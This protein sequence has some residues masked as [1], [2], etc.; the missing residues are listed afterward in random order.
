MKRLSVL[1]SSLFIFLGLFVSCKNDIKAEK[2][3]YLTF[4]DVSRVIQPTQL[5]FAE[6][7]EISFELKGKYEESEFSTLRT[8]SYNEENDTAYNQMIQ[9]NIPV[10]LGKWDFELLAIKNEQPFLKG[11]I[12][13]KDIVIGENILN[14]GTM[15]ILKEEGLTGSIN[16]QLN[17]LFDEI[18]AVKCGLYDL[19]SNEEI[20]G[21]VSEPLNISLS[22][23]GT[24]FV[25]YEKSEV[26]VGIYFMK[27]ELYSDENANKRIKVYSP[28]INVVVGHLTEGE[29]VLESINTFYTIEY[30]LNGASW[31]DGYEPETYFNKNALVYL[32]SSDDLIYEGYNFLGW[33]TTFDFSTKI[34]GNYSLP[35]DV[36]DDGVTLYAKWERVLSLDNIFAIGDQDSTPDEVSIDKASYSTYDNKYGILTI[37]NPNNSSSVWDY[38]VRTNESVSF[39][40]EK[41]YSVSVDLKSEGGDTVVGIQAAYAD[42]FFTVGKDW[43]TYTFETGF[44]DKELPEGKNGI[45][46]GSALASEVHISN[47]VIT[48]IGDDNLPTLAF[49]VTKTGIENYLANGKKAEN[50][51]E[52]EKISS[53]AGYAITINTPL[54]SNNYDSTNSYL[55]NDVTL[56]LRDYAKNK[57]I[58]KVSFGLETSNT[59]YTSIVADTISPNSMAWNN[60][61]QTEESLSTI[62]PVFEDGEE[63][64]VSIIKISN[65]DVTSQNKTSFSI[66]NFKIEKEDNETGKYFAIKT[67]DTTTG[68]DKYTESQSVPVREAITIPGDNASKEFDVLMYNKND[69]GI[70]W[71]EVTRFIYSTEEKPI[72]SLRYYIGDDGKYY[73]QNTGSSEISCKITLT[74]DFTVQIEEVT[75]TGGTTAGGEDVGGITYASLP[76]LEGN[77]Y[78]DTF[79]IS[80]SSGLKTYR[81][82]ING[83]QGFSLSIQPENG[84]SYTRTFTPSTTSRYDAILTSNITIEDAWIPIGTSVYPFTSSF[85]GQGYSITFAENSSFS[86]DYAGVFGYVGNQSASTTSISNLV[87]KGKGQDA[88]ITTSAQYAGGIVAYSYGA[89]ISN[90][91]NKLK[92]NNTH[93]SEDN[94]GVGGI[95]GVVAKPTAISGCVNFADL[96]DAGE[97]DGGT[98]KACA[99]GIVGIV[100]DG[101][102]N[103]NEL[104]VTK[105]I[106]LG[107][108]KSQITN[109]YLSGGV[110]KAYG[111]VNITDCINLGEIGWLNSANAN[112]NSGFANVISNG[113][114]NISTCINA[115]PY[116][117]TTNNFLYAIAYGDLNSEIVFGE[118]L[119]YNSDKWKYTN[120]LTGGEESYIPIENSSGNVVEGKSTSE[121]C[122]LTTNALSDNWFCVTDKSR[123]PLP[124]LSSVF[125]DNTIWE[126]ICDAAKVEVSSGGGEEEITN[127]ATSF[128]ELNNLISSVS[129]GYAVDN[130]YV[131]GIENDITI[132]SKIT[133]ANH[134]KLVSLGEE[135]KL[136][137]SE[138]LQEDNLFLVSADASLTLGD[139]DSTGSLVIDGGAETTSTT[140]KKSLINVSTSGTL[141]L[142]EN[143]IL[144]NNNCMDSYDATNGGAIYSSGGTINING[145]TIRNNSTSYK[146]HYGGAIYLDSGNFKMSSGTFSENSCSASSGKVYGGALYLSYCAVEITGGEFSNNI[147]SES[148]DSYGGAIYI[149]TSSSDSEAAVISNC[150]FESNTA[151]QR[152]GAIYSGGTGNVEIKNCNF[153]NN[154]VSNDNAEGGAI[155]VGNTDGSVS[156]NECMFDGNTSPA[157]YN[158]QLETGVSVDDEIIAERSGWDPS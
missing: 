147:V 50:I 144:Q 51:I 109:A 30:E 151:Y 61:R 96:V 44:L 23:A 56:E 57:G 82:L 53:N 6:D 73:I 76:N 137:R 43:K 33:Y 155:Y 117:K 59:V 48:E 55:Y 42:M 103:D 102:I 69:S 157:I 85:D 68:G 31:K 77:G 25:C 60:K 110:G 39:S 128:E 120:I 36:T 127:V 121:L 100:L 156:V 134:I 123:Y 106:N 16:F 67:P 18:K 9:S 87:V 158:E 34:E 104:T 52:V 149:L 140:L 94:F 27:F 135:C 138:S 38:Y 64:T 26:P 116:P 101:N 10:E 148:T 11:S 19:N 113:S 13:D 15:E 95:V 145:G 107:N 74:E 80:D 70:D 93:S 86:G 124:D 105:C 90:C 139:S 5:S 118:K 79:Y 75:T 115:G 32:P 54:A 3:A 112:N 24:K 131:I 29:D 152:G 35:D 122:A 133:I 126:D 1:V 108:V 119:Y 83:V 130:P 14:F 72:N 28:V 84:T 71:D 136:V 99:G 114:L 154:N 132:E 89:T 20:E 88:G 62:F 45:T 153:E 98:Q 142:N 129:S 8:W 111:S 49:N 150:T 146:N 41:N 78:I 92:I 21:F 97:S 81:D 141:V 125:T 143:S 46:I 7:E 47:L 37:T 63:V 58:N 65:A 66:K 4:G 2:K 22:D 12:V 17:F 40:Q 91:V